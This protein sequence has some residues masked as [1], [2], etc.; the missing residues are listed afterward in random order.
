LASKQFELIV[1]KH[2]R[3]YKPWV[4]IPEKEDDWHKEVNWQPVAERY[5]DTS[6][7]TFSYKVKAIQKANVIYPKEP[8]EALKEVVAHCNLA[9]EKK[10]L[11]TD[12]LM[13]K[14][15]PEFDTLQRANIKE[16]GSFDKRIVVI[17]NEF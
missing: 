17:G 11:L 12:E 14:S 10:L 8:F 1:Q 2:P 5:E 15:L 9:K 6:R 3:L 13:P 7:S 4:V 16:V